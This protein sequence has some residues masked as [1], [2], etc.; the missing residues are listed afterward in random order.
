VFVLW[1]A[2]CGSTSAIPFAVDRDTWQRPD[3]QPSSILMKIK[4]VFAWFS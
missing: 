1:L 2:L 3:E 4:I